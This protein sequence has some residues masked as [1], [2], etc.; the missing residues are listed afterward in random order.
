MTEYKTKRIIDKKSPL[1]WVIV[2]ETGSVVNRN[3]S[4]EELK[5]L[6]KEPRKPS[7][8]KTYKRIY[9]DKE[10][11]D[12]LRRF[13]NENG[14]S[15]GQN[16]FVNNPEYPNCSIYRKRFGSWNDALIL[17]GLDINKK[18]KKYTDKELLDYLKQFYDESGRIPIASD[19]LN[20]PEYPHRNTYIKRFESWN[21]ALEMTEL[22]LEKRFE[23]YTDEELLNE[24]KRFE[25]EEGKIPTRE[26]FRTYGEY[27]H[28][29]TYNK[30][31]G[32]WNNALK[33]VEM[34]LD[35]RIKQ[36]ELKTKIESG[37]YAE[38]KVI[39]HF[40]QHP[41]DLSGDNCHNYHDGICPNGQI[42]EVKSSK[43]HIGGYWGF[44]TRNKDKDDDKEAIQWYY[45][46][47]FNDDYTKIL[48]IWRVPGELI[49]DNHFDIGI[50][51]NRKFNIEN[52]KK[53]DITNK[54]KDIT[55]I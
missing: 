51:N 22:N 14:R 50:N 6:K 47:A 35:T 39:N 5:C 26:D 2:D 16:D 23:K 15:P 7:D 18:E 46:I 20:N 32:G 29:Q 53:Y 55:K 38:I 34:D 48:Y 10:L 45:F 4:E 19:F 43:L 37:R 49:G 41:I 21:N 8:T 36:G 31:F 54:F 44:H 1:R 11:L 9:T 28:Y 25:K 27:P 33:L 13:K 12:Y 3:P 40:K 24:L 52:M 42:Y 30:R 17:L